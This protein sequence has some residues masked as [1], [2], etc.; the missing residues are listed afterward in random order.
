MIAVSDYHE[1][2]KGGKIM[3]NTSLIPDTWEGVF[4]GKLASDEVIAP[5][6]VSPNI[7]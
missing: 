2:R 6:L 1:I 3:N 7:D 5:P 4:I